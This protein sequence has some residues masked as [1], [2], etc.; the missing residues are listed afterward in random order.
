MKVESLEPKLESLEPKLESLEF[1]IKL[2]NDVE[3]AILR[4]QCNKMMPPH[5]IANWKT[6]EKDSVYG[7]KE[8]GLYHPRV[9]K[10]KRN[11][12]KW[13]MFCVSCQVERSIKPSF[14]L[15]NFKTHLSPK[16][17]GVDSIHEKNLKSSLKKEV[18]LEKVSL[19]EKKKSEGILKKHIEWVQK[20]ARKGEIEKLKSLFFIKIHAVAQISFLCTYVATIPVPFEF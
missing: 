8:R 16:E 5:L 13:V 15:L 12:D 14:N 19:E 7:F 10:E 9:S 3:G 18:I 6:L 4:A 2:G 11:F 20:Y 17:N 1:E